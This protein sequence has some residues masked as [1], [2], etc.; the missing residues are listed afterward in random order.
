MLLC[1]EYN[2]VCRLNACMTRV[3]LTERGAVTSFEWLAS[4]APE[5]HFICMLCFEM[6]PTGEAWADDEGQRWNVCAPCRLMEMP[7]PG[8]A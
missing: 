8:G 5:G 6:K 1:L 4:L 7:D 3:R 2:E